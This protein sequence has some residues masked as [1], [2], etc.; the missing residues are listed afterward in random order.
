MRSNSHFIINNI[1]VIIIWII[2]ANML[3]L[4]HTTCIMTD[5]KEKQMIASYFIYGFGKKTRIGG[6]FSFTSVILLDNYEGCK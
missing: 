2:S 4:R 3:R 6:L 5:K 1:K